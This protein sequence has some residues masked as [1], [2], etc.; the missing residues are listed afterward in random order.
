MEAV[1]DL[2]EALQFSGGSGISFLCWYHHS[3]DTQHTKTKTK[4]ANLTGGPMPQLPQTTHL[5]ILVDS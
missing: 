3:Y 2:C 4:H 1:A 5:S